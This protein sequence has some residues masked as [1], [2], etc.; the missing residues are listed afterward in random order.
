MNSITKESHLQ[1]T[2]K[3]ALDVTF[4]HYP[5]DEMIVI[6]RMKQTQGELQ[7]L[8]EWINDKMEL[9]IARASSRRF[10]TYDNL[11]QLLEDEIFKTI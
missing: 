6:E 7:D 1:L 3:V 2:E 5:D 9:E 4:T 10:V 11:Y 8:F